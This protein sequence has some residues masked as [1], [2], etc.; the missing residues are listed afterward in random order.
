M[1]PGFDAVD[2]EILR[3]LGRVS[4]DGTPLRRPA[5]LVQRDVEVG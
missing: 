2:L 4:R 5:D 1:T 3:S